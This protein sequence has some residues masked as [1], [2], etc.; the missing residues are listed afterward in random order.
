MLFYRNIVVGSRSRAEIE[1]AL[2]EQIRQ[3]NLHKE[4]VM[5]KNLKN[6]KKLELNR[7][8]LRS[9]SEDGMDHVQGGIRDTYTCLTCPS[10]PIVC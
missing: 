9:M 2:S 1:T 7:E 5:K 6:A 4:R 3:P 10:D 8:T